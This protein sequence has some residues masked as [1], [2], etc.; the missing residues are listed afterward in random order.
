MLQLEI[1]K[2]LLIKDEAQTLEALVFSI[3][4]HFSLNIF[5][6]YQYKMFIKKLTRFVFR[7]MCIH[8]YIMNTYNL[9]R[10]NE[11]NT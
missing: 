10:N 11:K 2:I 3:A 4:S 6:F 8:I 5:S 9:F 1:K 7:R